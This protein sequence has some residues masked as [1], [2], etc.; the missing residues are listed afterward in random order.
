MVM[1]L[2]LHPGDKVR[3]T[4]CPERGGLHSYD[5]NVSF[6]LYDRFYLGATI[7]AYS[8]DYKRTSLY[9]ERFHRADGNDYGGYDLGNDYWTSGGG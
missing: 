6:N 2:I 8:L 5:F 1:I 4:Y 7:G 9:K 3:Q